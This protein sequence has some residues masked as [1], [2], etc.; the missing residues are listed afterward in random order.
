MKPFRAVVSSFDNTAPNMRGDELLRRAGVSVPLL[1]RATEASDVAL[2]ES[3]AHY[4]RDVQVLKKR[5]PTEV[6]QI[7]DAAKKAVRC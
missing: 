3:L 7:I 4:I 2:L 1:V 6:Q 5:E